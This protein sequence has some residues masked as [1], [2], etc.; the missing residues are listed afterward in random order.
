MTRWVRYLTRWLWMRV[1]RPARV[2]DVD[3]RV[4][5]LGQALQ[6]LPSEHDDPEYR[7][8]FLK[9][10]FARTDRRDCADERHGLG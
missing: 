6:N 1:W 8:Q 2:R 3:R 10:L 9:E 7:E 5:R 4:Q